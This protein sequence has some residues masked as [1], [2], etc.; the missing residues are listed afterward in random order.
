M[1]KLTITISEEAHKEL[2]KIQLARRLEDGKKTSLAD[3]TAE[4][5]QGLLVVKKENP[6]K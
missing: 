6:T 3:V 2:L 1:K 4:V 5:L